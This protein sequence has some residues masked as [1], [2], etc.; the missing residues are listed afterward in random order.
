MK[1]LEFKK[2]WYSTVYCDIG[3][4]K[5]QRHMMRDAYMA[6]IRKGREKEQLGHPALELKCDGT[7]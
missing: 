2:W 7:R 4:T 5:T 3:L 1:K 6:G